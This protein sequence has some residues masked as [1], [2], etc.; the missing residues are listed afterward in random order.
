MRHGVVEQTN[1]RDYALARIAE[2]PRATHMELI[3]S[4]APPEG[5]ASLACRRWLRRSRTRCLR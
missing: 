2:A 1:F 4:T 5:S 3:E